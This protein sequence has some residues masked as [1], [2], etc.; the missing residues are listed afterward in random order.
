MITRV[1]TM[2]RTITLLANPRMITAR[3]T[4]TQTPGAIPTPTITATAA[5]ITITR[6]LRATGVPSPSLS[7]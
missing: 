4:V 2:V 1:T 7:S 5:T 6:R 3:T